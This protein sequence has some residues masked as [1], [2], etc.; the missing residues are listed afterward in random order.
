M[1]AIEFDKVFVD[2]MQIEDAVWQAVFAESGQ[3][4]FEVIG[5]GIRVGNGIAT[6][7]ETCCEYNVDLS[8]LNNPES[9]A[10]RLETIIENG[11]TFPDSYSDMVPLDDIQPTS[12]DRYVVEDV[13]EF[14]EDFENW[15]NVCVN[16]TE[17]EKIET[18]FVQDSIDNI[19]GVVE[20]KL[21][22]ITWPPSIVERH[23]MRFHTH[24]ELGYQADPSV[25]DLDVLVDT[26]GKVAGEAVASTFGRE[27]PFTLS[28][29]LKYKQGDVDPDEEVENYVDVMS[30]LVIEEMRIV[31][32]L[33]EK[34]VI[35]IDPDDYGPGSVQDIAEKR[36]DIPQKREKIRQ[37]AQEGYRIEPTWTVVT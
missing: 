33:A 19:L 23:G 22:S 31:Q 30:E 17:N 32:E 12:I 27:R 3:R 14:Y 21:G 10:D 36:V 11:R 1:T 26:K 28:Y 15:V 8:G 34:G 18:G 24:P 13:T 7:S 2:R 5:D 37:M 25:A 6:I 16:I 4:E 35:D 9:I 29:T 20:G